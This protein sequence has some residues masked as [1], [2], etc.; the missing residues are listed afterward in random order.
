MSC[1][2]NHVET[3]EEI[4]EHFRKNYPEVSPNIAMTATI[5]CFQKAKKAEIKNQ[6]KAEGKAKN[7]KIKKE[8][9]TITT[10]TH[11]TTCTRAN[12][13]DKCDAWFSNTNLHN[14]NGA[15]LCHAYACR[16]HTKLMPMG[17]GLFCKTHIKVLK[18]IRERLQI[19]KNE[20]NIFE[21]RECRQE[22]ILFRKIQHDGHTYWHTLVDK[23]C[24]LLESILT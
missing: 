8:E 19:A 1:L 15:P 9:F 14:M 12:V 11:T 17:N 5:T 18:D 13:L 6:K 16:I 10:T 3:F 2:Q 24:K 23:H 21:E 7:K 22:E 20:E 4:Y